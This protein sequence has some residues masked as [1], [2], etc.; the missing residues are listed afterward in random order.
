MDYD[1]NILLDACLIEKQ[2][3]SWKIYVEQDLSRKE[4]TQS[5]QL[6]Q[7]ETAQIFYSHSLGI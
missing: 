4:K 2:D 3:L 5:L 1:R 7:D 6:K